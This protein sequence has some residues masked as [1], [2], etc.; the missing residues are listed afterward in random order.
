M[1]STFVHRNLAFDIT[2]R[3]LFH[4]VASIQNH[5]HFLLYFS[6]NA[7]IPAPTVQFNEIEHLISVC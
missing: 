2:Q 1:S 5:Y 7:S 3:N 4:P 6:G